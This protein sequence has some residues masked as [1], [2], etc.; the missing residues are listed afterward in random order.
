MCF[1][2][3]SGCLLIQLDIE[4]FVAGCHS[5]MFDQIV[6]VKCR[7]LDMGFEKDISR[8]VLALDERS[9]CRRQTLLLSATLTAGQNFT[10]YC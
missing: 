8:V 2:I 5:T 9:T 10:V 4:E 6:T 1:V 3:V 7:L